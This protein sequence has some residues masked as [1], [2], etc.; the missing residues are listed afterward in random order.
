LKAA[1]GYILNSTRLTKIASNLKEI[2]FPSLQSRIT[3][4]ENTQVTMQAG[5]SSIKKMAHME[6]EEQKEKA[7][8]KENLLALS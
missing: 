7:S 6:L 5:I 2:K 8:Q 3:D 4:I 1:E